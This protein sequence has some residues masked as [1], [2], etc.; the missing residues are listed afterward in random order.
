MTTIYVADLSNDLAC[1]EFSDDMSTATLLIDD[2]NRTPN[3]Y[4]HS[5]YVEGTQA[6]G[7]RKHAWSMAIS[8]IRLARASSSKTS[9]QYAATAWDTGTQ[10]IGH[11][12]LGNLL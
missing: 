4:V 1:Y 10:I 3:Q 5:I 9:G 12:V 6:A 2:S 11:P 7:N 8:T